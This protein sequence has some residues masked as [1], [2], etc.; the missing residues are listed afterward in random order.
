MS[1]PYSD[2][3][4][5]LAAWFAQS[6]RSL[7]WRDE[8]HARDPYAIAVSE[9]MLQQTTVAA[10]IPF[11]QRFLAR[12]PTAQSLAEAPLDDVLA[13]WSGL[14][15]YSR[16]RNL[17]AL[18]KAVAARG[19]FPREHEEILALPGV[20][21][22]TAG[23]IASIAYEEAAP[24][25]DANVA[26]VFAR[27][28]LIEGDL[29]R[30]ENAARLWH[31]AEAG[32]RAAKEAGVAPSQYNPALMELGSLICTP[33]NP[34]CDRCPVEAYCDARR[35]NRQNEIPFV[36][37]RAKPTEMADVC[38]RIRST[39][40]FDRTPSEAFWLRQRSHDTRIWWRG[41]WELPRTTLRDGED[42]EAALNRL[43]REELGLTVFQIGAPLKR[44]VH[45]VTTHRI[46]L[47]CYEVTTEQTPR[48]AQTFSLETSDSLAMPAAMR[49]L[50]RDLAQLDAAPRQ[51]SL[52]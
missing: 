13:L 30:K 26:R 50:L 15:Y 31:E 25:V 45:G 1:F 24:I 48:D 5:A 39:V 35:E 46:T 6:Q 34:A 20:G 18:G 19:A 4:R 21:R 9:F 52:F 43:L 47:D 23:A 10:V 28:F 40:D 32:V 12:F 33:K 49:R 22:Y 27:V 7:P 42:A 51:A 16:A 38:V 41:M 11:Y 29:K 37:P 8:P 3:A 44:I 36:A 2:F 17:H 14:G